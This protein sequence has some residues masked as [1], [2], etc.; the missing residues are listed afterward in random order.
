[1]ASTTLSQGIGAA[2]PS[3]FT[4]LTRRCC[5]PSC[6]CSGAWS[7]TPAAVPMITW[8]GLVVL[9]T[10]WMVMSWVMGGGDGVCLV[11]HVVTGGELGGGGKRDRVSHYNV[12]AHLGALGLGGLHHLGRQLCVCVEVGGGVGGTNDTKRQTTASTRHI[13]HTYHIHIHLTHTRIHATH[14]WASLAPCPRPSSRSARPR[15]ATTAPH[16][17]GVS[18]LPVFVR[19]SFGDVSF[20]WHP[21]H[22]EPH[23]RA[24]AYSRAVQRHSIPSNQHATSSHTRIT[25]LHPERGD[26]PVGL[27]RQILGQL[28]VHLEGQPVQ[29]PRRARVRPRPRCVGCGGCVLVV[30]WVSGCGSAG[31]VPSVYVCIYVCICTHIYVHILVVSVQRSPLRVR[32]CTHRHIHTPTEEAPA[33]ARGRRRHLGALQEDGLVPLQAQLVEDA[34]PD[35]PAADAVMVCVWWGVGD[36]VMVL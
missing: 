17:P 15:P 6:S 33:L 4:P 10:S 35:D 8:R 16:R 28:R 22:A 12:K 2:C 1:M 5:S 14:P 3:T 36:G 25:Y 24:L 30:G 23:T 13:H 18:R 11:M 7:S 21:A 20:H 34:R 27:E 32:A 19:V 29:L 31:R 26:G 9:G